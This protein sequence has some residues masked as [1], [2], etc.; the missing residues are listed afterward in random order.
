MARKRKSDS[1]DIETMVDR[2]LAAY[3]SAEPWQLEAG[4]RWYDNAQ[5]WVRDAA[6]RHQVDAEVVAGVVAAYSP[7]TRWVSNLVDAEYHLAGRPLRSG[8]MGSNVNRAR[9]VELFGL[10]GLGKGPKVNA[11]ARNILGDTDAVT[12]DV[13]A[14]RA[15]LDTEDERELANTLRW[16]GAYQLIADAYRKAAAETGVTPHVMQATVWVV[17]RGKAE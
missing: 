1:L 14:A 2:I 10:D 7:Q 8:V 13:W 16:V 17:T 5:Q 4:T 11:F 12:V 15:A 6:K 9:N 3:Y